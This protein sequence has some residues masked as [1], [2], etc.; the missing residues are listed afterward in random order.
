MADRG[1]YRNNDS[2]PS[3]S[4]PSPLANH[5]IGF[6]TI[7]LPTTLSQFA[8][9]YARDLWPERTVCVYVDNNLA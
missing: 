1:E 7:D 5:A 2:F 9:T 6:S 3:E 4:V 8:P